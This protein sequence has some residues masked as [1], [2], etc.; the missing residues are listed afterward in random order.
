MFM[1]RVSTHLIGQGKFCAAVAAAEAACASS[2][3]TNA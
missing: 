2:N 3:T 1:D